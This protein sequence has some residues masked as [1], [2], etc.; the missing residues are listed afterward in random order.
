MKLASVVLFIIVLS[1]A[2]LA[3]DTEYPFV[4]SSS[5]GSCLVTPEAWSAEQALADG[6]KLSGKKTGKL[7]GSLIV[8]CADVPKWNANGDKKR[9]YVWTTTREQCEA[10][11]KFLFKEDATTATQINRMK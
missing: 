10:L 8:N 2:A 11:S 9:P 4:I 5:N 3:A 6:C 7:G 1:G